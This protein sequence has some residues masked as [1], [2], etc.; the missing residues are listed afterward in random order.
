M[1]GPIAAWRDDGEPVPVGGPRQRCVL[2]ALLVDIGKEVPIDRLIEYLWDDDPPR[3][4]RSV[5]QVQVSHLR[6]TFPDLIVTTPGGYQ[7]DVAPDRVDL[8]RFRGLVNRAQAA[9][10]EE[11]ALLL[12]DRALQCWRG[13]P[14][15]G[16]GSDSLWYALGR[17][18]ME[19]RWAAV[20]AWAERAFSLRRYDEVVTRLTP[21]VREDPLRERLQ[22]LL[23]AALH[24]SGQ[25][26]AAL[27]AYQENRRFLAEELGV[28]PSAELAEL[29]ARILNDTEGQESRLAGAAGP[30]APVGE[31]PA[32]P[33]DDLP[34]DL[35]DFTG[36]EDD[37]RELL[38]VSELG[39]EAARVYVVSGPGGVGKTSLVVHAAHRMA[40]RFP[41]GRFFIDLHGFSPERDPVTPEAALGV[42]LRATGVPPDRV[43]DALEERSA[44]WRSQLS[45]HRALVVLDNA[46]GYSQ[47]SPLLSASSG[48]LTVVTSRYDLPG[49]SGAGHLSLSMFDEEDSLALLC[50]VLGETR[51]QSERN[52]AVEV[53][54]LCGG[55]PLALRIIAARMLNRPRWTFDHVRQRLSEQRRRFRELRVDG[56]SV[57]AV[58]E[59]SFH[60][61]GEE[62]RRFFSLLGVAIGGSFD[63][64]GAAV[65]LELSPPDTDDLLQELVSVCLLD[66][67]G[68]DF[69][70]FHDLIGDYARHKA[71]EV[72]HEADIEAARWRLAEYYLEMAN[73]AAGFLG[74]RAHAYELAVQ[75]KSRYDSDITDR[76]EAVAWFERHQDN[77]VSVVDF[78]AEQKAGEHTWQIAESVWRFYA[79]H[80]RTDHLFVTHE[81]AL[82]VSK[83]QGRERGT[84]V[85]LIGLG[86]AQCYAGRYRVAL[87]LLDD[88]AVILEALGDQE[89]LARVNSNRAM[90]Y[91]RL[92]RYGEALKTFIEIREI[93]RAKGDLQLEVL[94]TLNIALMNQAQRNSAEAMRE[95]EY[96]LNQPDRSVVW[97]L[98]VSALRVIGEALS[99][100]GDQ[101]SAGKYVQE[102]ISLS[103]ETGDH[104]DE[105]FALNALAIVLRRS[106]D[107]EQAIR[108][109]IQALELG[110]EMSLGSADSEILFELGNTYAQAG[111]KE[112]AADSFGRALEFARD[113]DERYAEARALLGLGTMES[114]CD[115]HE[116]EIARDRLTAALAIFT[117]LGAPGADEARAALQ[118]LGGAIPAPRTGDV[119]KGT[120]SFESSEPVPPRS[121]EG[122]DIPSSGEPGASDRP[123]Q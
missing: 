12:W 36:R 5:I 77:L 60:S 114:P 8:Y 40:E 97:D 96:I 31:A 29:H 115:S 62:Q 28:D 61:L 90:V 14:F 22:Y 116:A 123:D 110:G 20:V 42:L 75:D 80:G 53:A 33:R 48:S 64:H 18:L 51:V 76:D 23:I 15:S 37:L 25:R 6:R 16:T 21:V 101:E 45:G 50:T 59:L 100:L 55:L 46:A 112:E 85:T 70:R 24:R 52:G 54:R 41:D 72:L 118:N 93:A 71:H 106:G 19:E 109:H 66:E 108:T 79:S 32:A 49:V 82:A 74:P 57:E 107:V 65:L 89:G 83:E 81:K 68:V 111:K 26:A 4:A 117:E 103:R 27:N 73:K 39:E 56:Q 88:A 7:A 47:V 120:A 102:S 30:T 92:G 78:F 9:E 86:I 35:P 58:F 11:E 105:I 38:A 87:E 121:S 94:Q 119:P 95:A 43:P 91:E 67:H 3:T 99:D 104:S 122:V 98:R 69:Y 34:R 63:L 1:L 17:P 13:R 10:A 44:L 2:G 84:A 113:R